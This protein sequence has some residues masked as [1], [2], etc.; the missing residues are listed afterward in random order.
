MLSGS[1]V[2]ARA[3]FCHPFE[4]FKGD[5]KHARLGR[6]ALPEFAQRWSMFLLG[7][8]AKC[9]CVLSGPCLE[10]CCRSSQPPN[11]ALAA[12]RHQSASEGWG[13]TEAFRFPRETRP[14]HG[15]T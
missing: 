3:N 9:R 7:V 5:Q 8:I 12:T 6:A 1:I 4:V 15:Q 14:Q 2:K 11:R 10:G 13:P